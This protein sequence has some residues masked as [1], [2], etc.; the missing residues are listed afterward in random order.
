MALSTHPFPRFC[1]AAFFGAVI[2]LSTQRSLAQ[3]DTSA[4]ADVFPEGSS[5]A[6]VDPADS[7]PAL[8]QPGAIAGL[9]MYLYIPR[10]R[11]DTRGTS[12]QV[13]V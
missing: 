10:D 7:D 9:D 11:L 13:L 1:A 3:V 2:L 12:P 5:I 6:F 4:L 8:D